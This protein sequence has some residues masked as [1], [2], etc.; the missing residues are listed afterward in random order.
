[1]T[2][3]QVIKRCRKIRKLTMAKLGCAVGFPKRSADVRIAQYEADR[4]IPTKAI[5]NK[6]ANILGISKYAISKLS[7]ESNIETIHTLF[8]IDSKYGVYIGKFK[9]RTFMFFEP[10]CDELKRMFECWHIKQTELKN[11]EISSEEYDLWK[12][13]F[14]AV[15]D[16]DKETNA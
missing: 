7:I 16:G 8:K 4:A 3:G 6:L 14:G 5:K 10:Q 1:M 12:Y 15:S 2:V 11:G 9:E 13:G